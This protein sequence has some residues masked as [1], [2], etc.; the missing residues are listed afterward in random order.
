MIEYSGFT[1][2][3]GAVEAVREL[4]LS[5]RPGETLALVG[6]NGSGK[7]T[8]LKAALGLVR[9]TSG[10]VRVDGLDAATAGRQARSRLGYLPQSLTF[11]EGCGAR[12][13]GRFYA[14]LRGAPAADVDRLL[15][16]VGL[17]DAA[18]RTAEAFS[19]GMKQRLGI[20]L[21]LL[22]RP[23]ALVLDEP[24]AA[25]D[26]TGSLAV[27]DLVAEIA[28]EGTTVVLSSHD[29]AE[30]G[31]LAH[32]VAIFVAGRLAALGTPD[33][34]VASL[35]LRARVQV[36]IDTWHPDPRERAERAGAEA[37]DWE[38]GVLRCEVVPGREGALLD[39]LREAGTAVS[40]VAVR[41]PGLEEVYRAAT[42]GSGR[43][44]A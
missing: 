20:A 11:P 44:V 31:A 1:K 40:Q 28:A 32:R 18:G 34:L 39:A 38:A 41:A 10:A 12:E 24:T 5:V 29:L 25:L 36:G 27:R 3:F 15:D 6:P 14:R 37:V 16:R 26:P 7:T 35:G 2:R 22:G 17:A 13:V 23:R 4:D 30:V 33:E 43:R 19:G 42:A 9:P 21:A 8:T